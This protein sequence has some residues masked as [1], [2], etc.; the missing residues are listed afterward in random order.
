M[1]RSFVFFIIYA[2]AINLNAQHS[3]PEVF[4]EN[5]KGQ[6]VLLPRSDKHQIIVMA[7]GKHNEKELDSWLQPV[8][9]KFIQK[10]GLIDLMFDAHVY[11][12]TV[13]NGV[14]AAAAKANINKIKNETDEALHP[15]ILVLK[16]DA[17]LILQTLKP[18]TKQVHVY[19]L[20]RN[21]KVLQSVKGKYNE[22][23]MEALE[24]AF[25]D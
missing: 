16:S 7:F 6:Q 3:F 13:L 11:L 17:D 19:L 1:I 4:C 5:L 12:L 15:N 24:D 22:D 23:K 18:D 2:V 9:D 25:E 21:G 20:N 8:Y 10:T 14:E